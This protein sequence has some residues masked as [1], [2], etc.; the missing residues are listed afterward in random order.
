MIKGESEMRKEGK[1]KN[2]GKRMT[3]RYEPEK[4]ILII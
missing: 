4:E 3:I 2:D 1:C